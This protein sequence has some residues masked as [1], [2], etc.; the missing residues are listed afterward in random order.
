MLVTNHVL[1]GAVIGAAS[2][3]RGVCLALGVLSHFALDAVTHWESERA[4]AFH[5]G[6]G[7]PDGL[8]GLPPSWGAMTALAPRDAPPGGAR[9]REGAAAA[10]HRRTED[11]STAC[12]PG[13]ATAST[14]Q[15]ATQ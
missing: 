10:H 2:R 4:P 7:G 12:R 8:S 6:G 9:G 13:D 1:S 3:R 5:A 11:R 15:L 14:V